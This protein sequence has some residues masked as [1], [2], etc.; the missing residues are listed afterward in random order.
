MVMIRL[1]DEMYHYLSR[2]IGKI[3]DPDEAD[4]RTDIVE[5]FSFQRE[6]KKPEK[7]KERW[8]E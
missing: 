4:T 5:C 7:E 2:K 3:P 8:R 6:V 1:R